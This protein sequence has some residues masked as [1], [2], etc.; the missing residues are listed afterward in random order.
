MTT[1]AN[2]GKKKKI[3]RRAVER[4]IYLILIVALAIYG[5]KDSEAAVSLINAIKEAFSILL[6]NSTP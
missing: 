6:N 1:P 5:L 4:T 3:T 2:D